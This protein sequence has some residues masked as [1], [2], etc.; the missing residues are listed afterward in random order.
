MCDK[1]NEMKND[2]SSQLVKVEEIDTGYEDEQLDYENLDELEEG[3]GF[4]LET[5]REYIVLL[6]N[7]NFSNYFL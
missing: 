3:T 7:Y 1:L 6:V 2:Q 4:N 5:N